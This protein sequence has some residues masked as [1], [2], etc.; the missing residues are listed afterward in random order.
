MKEHIAPDVRLTSNNVMNR[1]LG[2]NRQDIRQ[3]VEY[4]STLTV[5][6]VMTFISCRM[7]VSG[8]VRLVVS[9][10][11]TSTITATHVITQ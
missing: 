8:V 4:N 7:I 10:E 5:P 2:S 6:V 1:Y 9:T 3:Q 11:D